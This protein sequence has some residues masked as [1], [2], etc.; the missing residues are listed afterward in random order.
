MSLSRRWPSLA[1]QL[2][3]AGQLYGKRGPGWVNAWLD[4]ELARVGDIDFARE[5]ADHIDLPD[6]STLDYAHRVVRTS[7][8]ELLGGIR[9][10]NRNIQRPFV[11]IVAHS[12]DDLDAL[13][14]CVAREWSV[15]RARFMRLRCAPGRIGGR[16]VVLDQ[17][18]YVGRHDQMAA[19]DGRVRLEI[20]DDVEEAIAIVMA[21][22]G[23]LVDDDPEFANNISPASAEDLRTWHAHSQIRAMR[24]GDTTVGVLAIAPGSVGWLT[25]DEVNEEVISTPHRGHGYAASAQ[26]AWAAHVSTDRSRLLIGTIDRH[27]HASRRTAARAGRHR[28][29]DYVFVA[30]TA[31]CP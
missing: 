30:L 1:D 4:D 21:R 10:Y 9:F 22:Y 19:P 13:A 15:F 8:G 28:V 16:G 31:A 20:I 3:V 12:F 17:S 6:V 11:E 23:R 29:L 2:D 26:L 27:N 14:E 18:I 7:R 24:V 25:G 5:F